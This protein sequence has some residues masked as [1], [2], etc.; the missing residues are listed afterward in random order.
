MAKEFFRLA[1]EEVHNIY[2]PLKGAEI[3]PQDFAEAAPF[4]ASDESKF[5]NGHNLVADGQMVDALSVTT[6]SPFTSNKSKLF[7]LGLGCV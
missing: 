5:V 3:E 4:L 7:C 6:A 2:N 1:D